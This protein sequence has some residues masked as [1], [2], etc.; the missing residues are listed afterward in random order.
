MISIHND[1]LNLKLQNSIFKSM[2]SLQTTLQRMMTG[3]RVN[4]AA[5]DPAGLYIANKFYTQI[6]GLE[7]ANNNIQAAL[8]LLGMTDSSIEEIN[9]IMTQIRD[10]V[11]QSTNEYMTPAEREANQQKIN[12]LYM[13]AQAIKNN[14]EYNGNKLFANSTILDKNTT[15]VD[16]QPSAVMSTMSSRSFT[17]VTTA[18][19]MTLNRIGDVPEEEPTTSTTSTPTDGGEAAEAP[20]AAVMAMSLDDET[21]TDTDT[22]TEGESVAAPMMMR[23]MSMRSVASTAEDWGT[24]GS[25]TFAAGETKTVAIN[26]MVYTIE[27]TS[28]SS[29]TVTYSVDADGKIKFEGSYYNVTAADGQEDN[30]NWSVAYGTIDTGDM[31]DT[32]DVNS[33]GGT[34]I[35]GVHNDTINVHTD[36][37][38]T[39]QGNIIN[40]GDGTDTLIDNSGNAYNTITN[41]E[42]IASGS[43]EIEDWGT[44]GVKTLEA[45]ET[46][47][48]KING[49]TYTIE[50]L[51]G[52][53]YHSS[54]VEYSTAA[55]GTIIFTGNFLNI[56]A[57][58]GQDDK[59]LI[60]G[61]HG[62]HLTIYT[63][64]G[65]D[66][67]TLGQH[68]KNIYVDGGAGTDTIID[69]SVYT[70][71]TI[72]NFETTG[73]GE[74]EDWGTSG[75]KTIAAGATV[76]A[77]I[78]GLIYTITNN[79]YYNDNTLTYSTEADGK[80]YF[81]G[82][83]C[84]VTA[85]SG[86]NDNIYWNISGGS[87]NTGDENDT[88][89]VSYS[90][91]TILSGSGN[92]T[93]ILENQ[94][95]SYTINGGDGTDTII[96]NSGNTSNTI[97]NFETTGSGE[98]E[99]WGTSGTK[100]IAARAT[101]TAQ[102]NGLT[103]TI[104][105]SDYQDRTLNYS[106]DAS[107]QIT[108]SG[109]LFTIT[110][111]NGQNDNLVVHGTHN[112]IYTGDGDDILTLTA[113]AED[114]CGEIIADGGDGT[115]TIIDNTSIHN[116]ITN[117]EIEDWGTSG[118]K[119]LEA[120]ETKTV[121]INGLT[122]TIENLAGGGYHS[123]TVEYSTAADGTIIFTGNFLNITAASGQDDKL[124]ID[125][126]HGY[127]LTIYT[128]DGNDTVTLGQHAK[129][130]YVDGG[131]G[132]DTIINNSGQT[133]NTITN[134]ETTGSGEAEDWGTSGSK[135]FAAG[136]TKTAIINGLVYTITN[137]TSSSRSFEYSTDAD[138]VIVLGYDGSWT[139]NAATGQNDKIHIRGYNIVLNTG[140]GNDVVI[141]STGG[142]T[143]NTGAGDDVV[144][145]QNQNICEGYGPSTV[146]GG[147]GN[148]AIIDTSLDENIITN[149]ETIDWGTEGTKTFVVGESVTA[150]IDGKTYTITNTSTAS[151]GLEWSAYEGVITFSS[152][153][154]DYYNSL[155]IVAADGQTDNLILEGGSGIEI[156]TGDGN[157]TI[158]ISN[159]NDTCY[160]NN[161][162]VHGGDGDDTITMN[163]TGGVVYGDAGIDTI[164]I[165]SSDATVY[166][167]GLD[168][169]R[170]N[171]FTTIT[172]G[173]S[174]GATVETWE[175]SGSKIFNSYTSVTATIDGKTYTIANVGSSSDGLRWEAYDDGSI[176]FLS[177]D[178]FSIIAAEGQ[179]DKIIWDVYGVESK[180]HTGDGDDVVTIG[181]N[182]IWGSYIIGGDGNDTLINLTSSTAWNAY[183]FET[184]TDFDPY[185][186]SNVTKL[187]ISAGSSQTINIDGKT[188][189]VTNSDYY[190][191]AELAYSVDGNG[192][193]TFS[194]YGYDATAASGQTDNIRWEVLN[195]TLNTGDGNDTITVVYSSSVG[196]GAGD[197]KISV[198]T[199]YQVNIDGGN[200]TDTLYGS[201]SG[202]SVIENIENTVEAEYWGTSGTKTIAAGATVTAQINGLTYTIE[203]TSEETRKITY[204]TDANGVITYSGS[205]YNDTKGLI[206]TAADGQDDKL[207]LSGFHYTTV[208]TGDG[209]DAVTLTNY[210][211]SDA[212]ANIINTGS[213]NDRVTL[214]NAAAYNTVDGGDGTD[215]IIDNSGQTSNTITNFETTGSGEAE[216]WGTSGTKT[217][218]ADSTITA[219]I[220][221]LTYT[222][223][224]SNYYEDFELT[225]ST[226]VNGQIKFGNSGN[227]YAENITVTAAEGQED[228]IYWSLDY[229]TLN[230]G[231]MEDTIDSDASGGVIIS[232]THNDTI[233]LTNRG[234]SVNA[235]DGDDT[236]TEDDLVGSTIDGGT[237]NDIYID[238]TGSSISNVTN[239]ELE[240]WGTSGTK[241]IAAGATVTAKINGLTYTISNSS[242]Y[243][244]SEL[245]YS[246]DASGQITFDGDYFTITAAD[247]QED[248]IKINGNYNTV[249]TGDGDD[250]V[251]LVA[252]SHTNTID[253]GDGA[254]TII[255]NSG[256]TSNTITNFETGTAAPDSGSY[257]FAAGETATIKVGTK[258][259]TVTNN[260]SAQSLSWSTDENGIISFEG[261]NFI[262]IAADGQ[263]DNIAINGERNTV[264]TGD[265]N[266]NITVNAAYNNIVSGA[267]DDTVTLTTNARIT[268]VAGGSGTNTITD[269]SNFTQQNTIYENG[270]FVSFAAGESQSLTIDGKTYVVT[271]NTTA[272]NNLIYSVEDGQIIFNCDNFIIEA[273]SGQSDNI[274]L[275]GD[276]NILDTNDGNDTVSVDDNGYYNTV[277]LGSGTNT[278]SITDGRYNAIGGTDGTN[279]ISNTA[280][281]G[282]QNFAYESGQV[283]ILESGESKIL[284]ID[285][286]TYTVT[287]NNSTT[288]TL[289]WSKDA[290]GEITFDA[291]N[292]TIQA[293]TGQEDTIRITGDDN[294][295]NT[296]N[297]NDKVT[298]T[299]K[300]A[301]S[302]TINAGAGCDNIILEE[303]Y[304]S[305]T[306]DGGDDSDT[307]TNNSGLT[308]NT[309]TNVETYKIDLAVGETKTVTI[310]DNT[311]TVE[312]ISS[313]A[314]VLWYDTNASGQLRFSGFD[315]NVTAADGQAD[316]VEWGVI[317]GTFNAGD[318]NDNIVSHSSGVIINAGSGDD[319][320]RLTYGPSTVD[321]GEGA[322]TIIDESGFE[323]TITNFEIEDW[324][325]SGSKT[326][327][328]NESKT[329]IIDGKTYTIT[330]FLLGIS[331]VITYS[332]DD[333]GQITFGGSQFIITAADGQE[334]NILLNG[335]NNLVYTGNEDDSVT[336]GTSSSDN[337]IDLGNGSDFGNISG[338]NNNVITGNEG[339]D[340]ITNSSNETNKIY[341]DG[342]A[343]SF[344]QN[345]TKTLTIDGKT[346]TIT[347]KNT[348]AVHN[349]LVYELK[350]GQLTF[351]GNFFEIACGEN[352][353]DNLIIYGNFNN[354]NTGN[355][356]D[357]VTLEANS[358][359]NT[360]E[361]GA[362]TDTIID[363]S[364][365][366]SNTITNFETTG[367]GELEDWGT[368][369][370][371]TIAAGATVTAQINGLT[372]TIENRDGT[373]ILTYST[374]ANG[375]IT[376]SGYGFN[377]TAADGQEDNIKWEVNGSMSTLDTGDE[378]DNVVT[379][380]N[381]YYS[382][383]NTGA[384]NDTISVGGND[385]NINAGADDDNVFIAASSSFGN[386]I[387]GGTGTNTVLN[388]DDDAT[389]NSVTNFSI[390]TSSTGQTADYDFAAGETVTLNIDDKIYTVTNIA[391]NA[392][393]LTWEAC[394]DG[395][396]L[397]SG[398]YFDIVA[399]DGQRDN[400]YW[401]IFNGNL[402]TG[403]G[404]DTVVVRGADNTVNTGDG[405]DDVVVAWS[406]NTVN[407]GTG[408]DYV[409]TNCLDN[410]IDGGAGID[411]IIDNSDST[412]NTI[413]NFETAARGTR[414]FAASETVTL[415]I[416]GKIYTVTNNGAANNEFSWMSYD[417]GSIL[418][419]GENFNVT[420]ANGQDDNLHFFLS[421]NSTLNT[422]DGN[423]T[424]RINS[425][426][427]AVVNAGSG[428]D[429]IMADSY[430]ENNTIDG[431]EGTDSLIDDDSTN[432]NIATNV[433]TIE[434]DYKRT[435]AAGESITVNIGGKIYT[436]T[437]NN[438]TDKDFRWQSYA[439]GTIGFGDVANHE[440]ENFTV[441]AAD[442]QEDNVIW[443]IDN[444]T[445]NTGDGD[446][447]VTVS[448]DSNT[449]DTG[450][451]V[452]TVT[453]SG[454]RNT[455]N[456]GAD[457]DSITLESGAYSNTIVGGYGTNTVTNNSGNT[458][459]FIYENGHIESF[460]ANETKTLTIDGKTYTVTNNNSYAGELVYSLD[461]SG[462][463]TFAGTPDSMEFT[464]TAADGQDDNVKT[465]FNIRGIL[466][467]GDG[468]DNVYISSG[469]MTVN[470]GSGSDN[471]TIGAAAYGTVNA[472]SGND[473]LTLENGAICIT[474][475]GGDGADTLIDNSGNT[476]N[477]FT[478]FEE[479][480]GTEGSKTLAEG[481]SKTVNI[482]GKVYTIT[483]IG[484]N[485]ET[486]TYST[487]ADGTITF[488]G[489]NI[490]VT[491][492]DGQ[493]DLINW[494]I[495]GGNLN[496][497]D[498]SDVIT[499][500]SD[501]SIV[502]SGDGTDEITINSSADNNVI[503]GGEGSDNITNNG[504][505]NSVLQDGEII[506]F[507]EGE[508]KNLTIGGKSYTVTNNY[509]EQN[510]LAYEV[511]EDGMISLYGSSFGVTASAGQVDNIN[512]NIDS[513][514]LNTGDRN[515]TITIGEKAKHFTIDGGSGADSIIDNN[516]YSVGASQITNV[517]TYNDNSTISEYTFAAGETITLN[518]DGKSYTIKN[519]LSESA[520]LKW[521]I[522]TDGQID[523]KSGSEANFT[524]TAGNGQEDNIKMS[525]G[526]TL[527]TGD[528][529]DI[530][531]V[532]SEG[533]TINAGAGDDIIE[534][535]AHGTI[536]NAGDDADTITINNDNATVNAGAG[537]D[538]VYVSSAGVSSTIDGGE[539][540]NTLNVTEKTDY[541][542]LTSTTNTNFKTINAAKGS[543]AD[544]NFAAGETITLNIDG[545]TYTITNMNDE[546]AVLEWSPY[547]DNGRIGFHGEGF[548]VVAANSQE[549][550]IV[551]HV[552][553]GTLNTGDG[554]DTISIEQANNNIFSGDGDDTIIVGDNCST[555]T[556]NNIDSGKG[557]D[558]ITINQGT[559]N[560][561]GTGDDT[562]D[563]TIESGAFGNI[564]GGGSGTDTITNNSTSYNVFAQDGEIEMFAAG[565]TR[566]ITID[567]KTYTIKNTLTDNRNGLIWEVDDNGKISFHG[568]YFDIKAADGQEDNIEWNTFGKLDTGDG[569]DT[570]T[571]S[572]NSTDS[573]VKTGAGDDKVI[574]NE[575]V[576]NTEVYG[577]DGNNTLINN[578]G[579]ST[580]HF[581][582]F[583]AQE[584]TFNPGETKE[585]IVG[586]KVYTIT[587]TSDAQNTVSW[588]TDDNGQTTFTGDNFNI[589]AADD[590]EDNI[591]II[592]SGWH[593]IDTGDRND[594]V[595]IEGDENRVLAGSGDDNIT[596]TAGNN[597]FVEGSAGNDTI[598]NEAGT[599]TE[600]WAGA[601]NDTITNNGS[602]KH[603]EI[604]EGTDVIYNNGSAEFI[605]GYHSTGTTTLYQN[606]TTETR[607]IGIDKLVSV[608][609]D[610]KFKFG[611]VETI[612]VEIDGKEYT[613]ENAAGYHNSVYIN[614][615]ETGAIKVEA[616]G[617]NVTAKN[618][619]VDNI[620]WA[621][622]N[623]TLDTGNYDDTIYV[624]STGTIIAG[625]GNDSIA[626]GQY[627]NNSTVQGGAGND[628]ISVN[629]DGSYIY[630]GADDDSIFINGN[631][632]EA[633]GD[634]GNDIINISG[635]E[636]WTDGGAGDDYTSIISGVNNY[637]DG[638]STGYDKV[639]NRGSGTTYTNMNELTDKNSSY[640][641]QVGADIN[642]N[643]TYDISAGALLPEMKIDI[644]SRENALNALEQLD[645]IILG[646]TSSRVDIKFQQNMLD[647]IMKNNLTKISNFKT[648]QSTI[649][650]ADVAE[651]YNKLIAEASK[652]ESLQLLQTQLQQNRANVFLSL[653]QSIGA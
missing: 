220:N 507:A 420:A 444:G 31:G 231:D 149:F 465:D 11:Q 554:N 66:T 431:G 199:D 524:I 340:S 53:G 645:E 489:Y 202:N 90:V 75:T 167:D 326:L 60:D 52:G 475:D 153:Y 601:G 406:N 409:E 78:N 574:V 289:V 493:E 616:D 550:D 425:T 260:S 379:T 237:G 288:A 500:N 192:Q 567:N 606:S 87:L 68:A 376:F 14:A 250:N 247:G 356:D 128:Q 271:N 566:D 609:N 126:Y 307:I 79:N 16:D 520:D 508:T 644:S 315:Y 492:A 234:Q 122:Y 464:I 80:I 245:I 433:E 251:E 290:G 424:I 280:H 366:T 142:A 210:G 71:N 583:G 159:A 270:E 347:N 397:F 154:G 194:G 328:A 558:T 400:I 513:G 474:A 243:S 178:S 542:G 584:Q 491:A 478:N 145:L 38:Y 95:N 576:Q 510:A 13:S 305:N 58:S 402:N 50:N 161:I 218:A 463:I 59:L 544:Y 535:D 545:K 573:E 180:L 450:T 157:D 611:D 103:Y 496:T 36:N 141:D 324:G 196:A 361:G 399:Q 177:N 42:N 225:Y 310:G 392:Q 541:P 147:E 338:G 571:L 417:D 488:N 368:S 383:I 276:S 511:D 641:I 391:D 382:N 40:A 144:Y 588:V 205:G 385:L 9:E 176:A 35:T 613:I 459:N 390:Y 367:S 435:F 331:N 319:T 44:S 47:T 129:N 414:D 61:Y 372:Y 413:T 460:A 268:T 100:T 82:W 214:D 621:V 522:N 130:I 557:N 646:L 321:G 117:F 501:N 156:Y 451:G 223:T 284:T 86:Q 534:T 419:S 285:G 67:V 91:G 174:S 168:I 198:L 471:I 150:T 628:D 624:S 304:M 415:D 509:G 515:D 551:W 105:N 636:N 239:V 422:G 597:V 552:S 190:S 10:L 70:T 472:G 256:Q 269:N 108:F 110:A 207:I 469:G 638:G 233:N 468:N 259:Y 519:E 5:D 184:V 333:S 3:L 553:N 592:G 499:V 579:N 334:D 249:D 20:T 596:I 187:T 564:I 57:A 146:D 603:I 244:D 332:V 604:G 135:T 72:T 314:N 297:E 561:I 479:N 115:D 442:G 364:G 175:S 357:T 45:G 487:A 622:T 309:I 19:G 498:E 143:I 626:V 648:S 26:G 642:E 232:G 650:D 17:P 139:I 274:S 434:A 462:Q 255:D 482:N 466:N 216:D 506:T 81:E 523:F 89:N 169:I 29:N 423:D 151:V 346:Y 65:N 476:Y 211:F 623:G 578:S 543:Q 418:I 437:N 99:D 119:T 300:A 344:D 8:N 620:H 589:K 193:I 33:S 22:E 461:A 445:L 51:A 481:E 125:G 614:K 514:T 490:N 221:G 598:T 123:S 6:R 265:N 342:V 188:Y 171:G 585:I 430:A 312:N 421:D 148:D 639:A 286:K 203:N 200:G 562:D 569:N 127:H 54:T 298:L 458:E 2:F 446:D 182:G 473:T 568:Y 633:S 295:V 236:I 540:N 528:G 325:T 467:T 404:D 34:I 294:I 21:G 264:N 373:E 398:Y 389:G 516:S 602:A 629:S 134:F 448:G 283:E 635:N 1:V 359:T 201:V 62:Y 64:D 456:T 408:D 107:G 337:S 287:N 43:G 41:V 350:N 401:N 131:E 572:K 525:V 352:Q 457:N 230:T 109:T 427:N 539:G 416:G 495:S 546:E 651:E 191:D 335:N 140:D 97:T 486:I 23:T 483:N 630:G 96:D 56:T 266:D 55:D 447:T 440:Y 600:I 381:T 625:D 28:G 158:T 533:V 349:I 615:T 503:A 226:D 235:G 77:Q 76:T 83:N 113:A 371:K 320:V 252:S 547:N 429:T 152:E 577:G 292:F 439:D 634:A 317:R 363:N 505:N 133:S 339:T 25:S 118:V 617:I 248:N 160:N 106:T 124:L 580:N 121:K 316:N 521:T 386:V 480:W 229:G 593:V 261:N 354:I 74:I 575:G 313:S 336:L 204:S 438:S 186:G 242:Y 502:A 586:D 365:N 643:S 327:A 527:N 224:N 426:D 93:V 436:I 443:G 301:F 370:T 112:T 570:V 323:N 432:T 219:V 605:G 4:S 612:Q 306:I 262:I 587:N 411:T 241:T 208:N 88:I 172:G 591:K 85:A 246:T 299:A 213:G 652:L 318:M 104:T 640:K 387:D 377:I 92:D 132:A 84:T 374:D 30:I 173:S 111:A 311:Y 355:N 627:A 215:T 222:I 529:A 632:N 254:D 330:N 494:N 441:T 94:A 303:N 46:K 536:I 549:D 238:K 116:T 164:T 63:Q 98:I 353:T 599:D 185:S 329:V 563:I 258:T 560:V 504:T 195:Q 348:A 647:S 378:N 497:G 537:D 453:V 653:I 358:I 369:G 181:N 538:I 48:V 275:R 395:Q 217:I 189:T 322:D 388:G 138:G 308:T 27:N 39:T 594:T 380:S 454:D 278:G 556:S 253:G 396:I 32:L 649:I 206:I 351:D 590:Q 114:T 155:K 403:D 410:N 531:Y 394:E 477:T 281:F 163:S 455:V 618:N 582:N 345:E 49:L 555:A 102:I 101:V 272:T 166:T 405:A 530:I 183:D 170:K 18:A 296:E 484:F 362:G 7:T 12:E 273:G 384:G 607:I 375:Q 526:G 197:D 341:E 179:S 512:W 518:I 470:A 581:Y 240:D 619:Q 517:S 302:N 595:I 291:D 279:S 227:D 393:T 162:T 532:S 165:T 631:E 452:D 257:D 69:N 137:N 293:A 15:Y 610:S 548:S 485:S 136:E 360:I 282:A 412:T 637:A 449:V 263:E 120:G 428:N 343:I 37:P 73:S 407:T 559:Y 267:G 565:E 24:S 608:N 212:C 277:D 209:N 228:N